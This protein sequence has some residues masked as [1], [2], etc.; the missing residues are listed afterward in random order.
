M[1]FAENSTI[2]QPARQASQSTNK[3]FFE[4]QQRQSDTS[5]GAKLRQA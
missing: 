4:H 1:G 5:F 3:E 2:L